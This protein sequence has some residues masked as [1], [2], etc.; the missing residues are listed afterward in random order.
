VSVQDV[1]T[2]VNVLVGGEPVSKYKERDEQF[3]VWL[4]AEQA[5]LH[6]DWDQ[7]E[8][9]IM[10]LLIEA[11]ERANGQKDATEDALRLPDETELSEVGNS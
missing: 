7:L 4:R 10:G 1:S 11:V 3:D 5:T 8:T 9:E 6:G 2:T